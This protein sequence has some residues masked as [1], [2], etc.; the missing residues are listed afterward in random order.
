MKNIYIRDLFLKKSG[1]TV[2]IFGWIS[3]K[4]ITSNFLFFDLVDSTGQIQ[5]FTSRESDIFLE[6]SKFQIET[7]VKVIGVLKNRKEGKFEIEIAKIEIIGNVD[8][9]ISPSPR[10][11]FNVFEPKYSDKVLSN[12]HLYLRN[13]KL[14]AVLKFRHVLLI[15]FRDW[16]EKHGFIEFN[17][18]ILTELLLYED[19]NIAFNID[20]FGKN[21]FLTQCMAFYL[22]SA[23]SAFEKVYCINP[24]FRAE[25]SRGK[26]YLAEYWH[27]KAEIAF[28]D[29]E[30]ILRFVEEMIVFVFNRIKNET[31]NEMA[32]LEVESDL[33][34]MNK[35]PFPRISYSDTIKILKKKGHKIEFGKSLSDRNLKEIGK[36]FKTLFWITGLPRK[37]E[38]YPYLI[39]KYN[40][41]LTKTADL[42]SHD[43]YGE[44]LGIAEKIWTPK[45]FLERVK[46]KGKIIEKSNEWYYNLR[47]FG[48]VPHSGF[49]M[50]IERIIRF[51]LK[52]NHT[53]DAIAFPRLFKRNPNP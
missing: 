4:H 52:L 49:G 35:L 9:S 7:S 21:V 46:E 38:P 16:F 3:R 27:L 51:L 48:S 19:E 33:S 44:L 41:K 10:S 8:F 25:K 29:F 31:Q 50:G 26:R 32:T 17:G 6:A 22:E 43:G 47:R 30:D 53:R 24:S 13:S 15:F 45:E 5:V 23:I 11:N 37:T 18:P 1:E 28:A 39:D 14:A 2:R 20:F 12:R 36:D 42:I 34:L 40:R